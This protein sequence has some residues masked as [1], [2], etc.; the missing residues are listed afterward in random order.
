V[1]LA[2]TAAL[3]VSTAEAAPIALP[4]NA[5]LVVKFGNFEQIDSS[6]SNAI[7][8]PGGPVDVDGAG[9]LAPATELNWGVIDAS[10]IIQG[11]VLPGSENDSISQVGGTP[12]W[13][14]GDGG[15][16][17]GIFYG[18]TAN[19]ADMTGT[20]ATNGWLDLYWDDDNDAN[21]LATPGDRTAQNMFTSYT[22]GTFLAR[23]AFASG[24]IDGDA[25][26]TIQSTVT[27][28]GLGGDFSGK[29][30]SYADVIDTNGD[31][32]IDSADGAWAS[33]LNGD[34]FFVDT[35]GDGIF[36]EPG[37]TRDLRFQN[38]FEDLISWNDAG[39]SDN[40]VGCILGALSSD[41]ASAFTVPAPAPLA[42][43]GI[44]FLALA[45]QVRR[46]RKAK[47]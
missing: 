10:S 3:G 41:P 29:A 22:D 4:N 37:E 31:G 35:D 13:G 25:V 8:Y 15:E 2:A 44:G 36:G 30:F 43:M 32:V 16:V 34:W 24:I 19:P 11:S 7:T 14:S 23:L 6:F 9:T 1:S 5:P 21:P 33:I 12:V 27:L 47:A 40:P 20:L 45:G 46:N 42:L 28:N 17:T 26:T 39:C 18:V 38:D